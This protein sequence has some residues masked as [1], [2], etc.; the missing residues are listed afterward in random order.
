MI[1]KN[2]VGDPQMIRNYPNIELEIVDTRT[3][4]SIVVPSPVLS[5]PSPVYHASSQPVETIEYEEVN[6]LVNVVAECIVWICKKVV[7]FT[8]KVFVL[9]IN[10]LYTVLYL[11]FK[12]L[13]E[14]FLK[15]SDDEYQYHYHPK[16]VHQ[17]N[18]RGKNVQNVQNN[19]KVDG[20]NNNVYITQNFNQK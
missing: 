9:L 14:A 4:P 13:Y 12:S 16:D 19:V 11:T 18:Q 3:H 15:S 5:V 2:S 20:Q 1:L 7:Q 10:V 17:T 8:W 6:E